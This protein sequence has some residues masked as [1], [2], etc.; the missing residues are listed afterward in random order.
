MRH[1]FLFLIVNSVFF[2]YPVFSQESV[3]K[4]S[5]LPFQSP[6]VALPQAATGTTDS[7]KKAKNL[8]EQNRFEEALQLT[9]N[10]LNHAKEV[11]DNNLVYECNDLIASVFKKSNNYEKALEYYLQN[12][13]LLENSKDLKKIAY[14]F[15]KISV[16]YFE[17]REIDKSEFYLNSIVKINDNS[18]EFESSLAIAYSGLSGIYVEKNKLELAEMYAQKA[19]EIQKLQS[20]S[21]IIIN[22]LNSLGSIYLLKKEYPKAKKVYFEALRILDS[23]G[24]DS[25]YLKVKEIL[26]DNLSY[27]LYMTKDYTAYTYQEKSFNIRDSLRDNEISRIL[28]EIEGKYNTENIKKEAQLKT[29]EEV[30]KRKHTQDINIILILVSTLLTLG[31]WTGYRYFKLRQ[32]KLKLE[33]IQSQLIQQ[34]ELEKIQNEAREKILNATLD[35]KE[36]ERKMIAETL[37]HSVSSL[38]S[39]ASLHLQASKMIMKNTQPEEIEKAH[40]IIKEAAEKIRNLSHSLVSSVLLKFGLK[41]ALQDMCEK[42]SNSALEFQCDCDGV[43][44]FDPDFELKINSIID[45]FLNNIIKHSKATQ[46]QIALKENNGNLEISINDNGKGFN[47]KI[48]KKDSGLG[49][50]Q[51]EARINKMEGIFTIKSSSEEGTHIYISVPVQKKEEFIL[52]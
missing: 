13:K 39:S 26:Y 2:L 3:D 21:I 50:K 34:S 51:I 7:L 27:V 32:E 45:E 11:A 23:K 30:A 38:L 25:K 22:T 40:T 47:P 35:G 52:N 18:N 46:A 48:P 24:D 41:Y 8:L 37:H 1:L 43:G 15:H 44:R 16:M 36:S 29:A 14:V 4:A 12:A 17:M 49:L 33:L 6:V 5:L 28:G 42:Y 31:I 20:E 10:I 19:L 9:L